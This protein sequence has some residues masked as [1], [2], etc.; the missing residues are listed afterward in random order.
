MSKHDTPPKPY[1]RPKS[2]K[3]V[4]TH[5]R[6]FS[7]PANHDEEHGTSY[8]HEHRQRRPLFYEYIP[9]FRYPF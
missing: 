4:E 7:S 3:R 9:H 2:A 8:Q 6:F 1:W 5:H